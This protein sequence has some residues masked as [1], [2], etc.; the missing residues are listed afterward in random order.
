M[1]ATRRSSIREIARIFDVPACLL[2][3]GPDAEADRAEL[4]MLTR[5][6]AQLVD[7]RTAIIVRS[8]GP[9]QW[10]RTLRWRLVDRR[11]YRRTVAA[12]AAV[13][14]RLERLVATR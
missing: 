11:A 8:W 1:T 9:A 3:T 7:H 2:D 4:A 13:D 10:A 14:D 6:R 12:L 5:R